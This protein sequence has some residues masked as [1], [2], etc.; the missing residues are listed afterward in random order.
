MSQVALAARSSQIHRDAVITKA[1]RL[2]FTRMELIDCHKAI[3]SRLARSFALSCESHDMK[4]L[5]ERAKYIIP[6]LTFT[7][8]TVSET[9]EAAIAGM[10]ELP[11]EGYFSGVKEIADL[12]DLHARFTQSY[13]ADMEF[14]D[15]FNE[16]TDISIELRAGLDLLLE[17]DRLSGLPALEKACQRLARVFG[18]LWS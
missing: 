5:P 4:D 1:Q 8:A 12:L 16:L 10:A 11:K 2:G 17:G 14:K 15:W 18:H 6:L 3:A 13:P 7:G 9:V